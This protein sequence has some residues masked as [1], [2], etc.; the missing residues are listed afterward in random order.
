M[1]RLISQLLTA[2][3]AAFVTAQVSALPLNHAE[4]GNPFSN[5]IGNCSFNGGGNSSGPISAHVVCGDNGG[6]NAASAFADVGHVGARASAAVFSLCC[7]SVAS[8]TATFTDTVTF[9]GTGTDPIPVSIN[10]HF[11]GSLNSTPDAGA[12]VEAFASIA[13]SQVGVLRANNQN[14]VTGCTTTFNGTI[15]GSNFL[16]AGD[17]HSCVAF[18]P[19]NTPVQIQLSLE[20]RA[21]ASNASASAFGEFSNSLDFAVGSDLF[22]L[23][24]GFTANSDTSLI[25]DNR[26]LPPTAAVPEPASTALLALGLATLGVVVRRSRPRYPIQLAERS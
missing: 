1:N 3:L 4:A 12:S 24:I 5:S 13:G 10:L 9:S 18:V 23:P 6:T 21:G 2:A 22:T 20:V 25:V 26:F 8:G 17:L 15:C 16:S 14:G 11:T 19:V 7:L